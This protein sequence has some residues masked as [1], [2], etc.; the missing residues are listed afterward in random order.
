MSTAAAAAA[1]EHLLRIVCAHSRDVTWLVCSVT[2]SSLC[3]GR[4]LLLASRGLLAIIELSVINVLSLDSPS[5]RAY[6]FHRIDV[7]QS[8]VTSFKCQKLKII[9]HSLING[10]V[11]PFLATHPDPAVTYSIN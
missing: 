4:L 6:V 9:T 1:S 5:D 10:F 2:H 7:A 11:R 3:G 8:I